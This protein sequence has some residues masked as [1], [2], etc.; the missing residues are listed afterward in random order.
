MVLGCGHRLGEPGDKL[1]IDGIFT[2]LMRYA[3]LE[4]AIM[5]K[6]VIISIGALRKSQ[7]YGAL[8]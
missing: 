5:V 1:L 2:R 3:W 6:H 4:Y 7:S 8:V